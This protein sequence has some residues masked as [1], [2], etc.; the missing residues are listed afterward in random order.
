MSHPNFL[1]QKEIFQQRKENWYLEAWKTLFALVIT[2]VYVY[3]AMVWW[4]K[5]WNFIVPTLEPDYSDQPITGSFETWLVKVESPEVSFTRCYQVNARE[6]SQSLI[7]LTFT[8]LIPTVWRC[9]F[10]LSCYFFCLW[11]T[12]QCC[13]S[14]LQFAD[15]SDLGKV[16]L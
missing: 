6:S 5:A 14:K 10:S 13:F 9:S 7:L 3:Y 12:D 8:S 1:F 11:W 15:L 16:V 4:T 2:L